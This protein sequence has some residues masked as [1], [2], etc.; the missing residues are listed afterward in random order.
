MGTGKFL[1][2]KNPDMDGYG[3]GPTERSGVGLK[4]LS[5]EGLYYP[6]LSPCPSPRS[7]TAPPPPLPGR[8]RVTGLSGGQQ[9]RLAVY[10]VN[11]RGSSPAAALVGRT[12]DTERTAEPQHGQ[13]DWSA[14]RSVH[15]FIYIVCIIDMVSHRYVYCLSK[16]DKICE[17][18][19]I[20]GSS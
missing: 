14:A 15:V 6:S 2:K 12:L 16:C 3:Y 20:H 7:L 8:L 19:N 18:S 13:S 9:Y 17:I 4:I 1:P 5:R 10:A 11:S